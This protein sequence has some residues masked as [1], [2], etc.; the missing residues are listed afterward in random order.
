MREASNGGASGRVCADNAA[1]FP[2]STASAA[3]VRA[4][5]HQDFQDIAIL[6]S[7]RSI[8]SEFRQGIYLH[9]R[10]QVSNQKRFLKPSARKMGFS[11]LEHGVILGP[12]SQISE[13]NFKSQNSNLKI[14]VSN[15]KF[16]ISNRTQ[17]IS[18]SIFEARR[19]ASRLP[20]SVPSV[21]G[22][23]LP[24]SNF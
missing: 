2:A 22:F 6:Q 14:Q 18:N 7:F 20:A 9:P 4:A 8:Q 3:N 13:L 19:A 21:S 5:L 1:K 23:Q 11:W 15:L 10:V 16:E 12:Y 24:T 17:L